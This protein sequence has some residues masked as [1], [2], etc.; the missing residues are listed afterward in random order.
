MQE[1]YAQNAKSMSSTEAT[2]DYAQS[3]DMNKEQSVLFARSARAQRQFVAHIVIGAAMKGEKTQRSAWVV[4]VSRKCVTGHATRVVRNTG[5]QEYSEKMAVHV[6]AG[7]GRKVRILNAHHACESI[8]RLGIMHFLCAQI[9]ERKKKST[10]SE[11]AG[12]VK[13]RDVFAIRHHGLQKSTSAA[14]NQ[15]W[16]CD[17]AMCVKSA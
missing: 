12:S 14:Q 1:N 2:A 10:Q 9:A 15:S 11:D 7:A 3:V 4:V 16:K 6:S 5:S 17:H 8:E 13:N